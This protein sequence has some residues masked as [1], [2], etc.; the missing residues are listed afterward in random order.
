MAKKTNPT[1]EVVLSEVELRKIGTLQHKRAAV[2][3]QARQALGELDAQLVDTL[4][5]IGSYHDIDLVN[6]K[7]RVEQGGRVLPIEEGEDRPAPQQL[8]G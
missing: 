1:P 6:G 3:Q 2:E 5:L 8:N 7:F 4:E